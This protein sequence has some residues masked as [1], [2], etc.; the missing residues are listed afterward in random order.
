M[1]LE[2][3]ALQLPKEPLGQRLSPLPLGR[4]LRELLVSL[5]VVLCC[6]CAPAAIERGVG[7]CALKLAL[8][9]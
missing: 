9:S 1:S 4:V 6:A 3:L 8:Q 2:F 7:D 5:K